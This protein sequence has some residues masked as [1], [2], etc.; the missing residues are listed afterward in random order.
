MSPGFIREINPSRIDCCGIFFFQLTL[1]PFLSLLNYIS[2][3]VKLVTYNS[4][5]HRVSFAYMNFFMRTCKFLL[6]WEHWLG[7]E[8]L[9]LFDLEINDCFSY[10]VSG[11]P[12][13]ESMA[14]RP[15]GGCAIIW[16]RNLRW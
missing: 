12:P 4:H 14:G 13:D 15:H 6:V 10:A 8:C 7:S 9:H 11:M 3:E 5:G 1:P 2:M 16:K